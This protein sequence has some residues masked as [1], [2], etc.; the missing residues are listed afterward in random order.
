VTG[1]GDE[2]F[3]NC[4]AG[5]LVFIFR[6]LITPP[7]LARCFTVFF[8]FP[9]RSLFSPFPQIPS[10]LSLP[11]HQELLEEP[12]VLPHKHRLLPSALVPPEIVQKGEVGGGEEI[13]P[14]GRGGEGTGKD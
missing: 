4:G 2:G 13:A 3:K 7:L 12:C 5:F 11:L 6:P 9:F 10:P 8:S 14:R 1:L